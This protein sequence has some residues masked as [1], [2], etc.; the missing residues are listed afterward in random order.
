MRRITS[1]I[2]FSAVRTGTVGKTK[3]WSK[4][5]QVHRYHPPSSSRRDVMVVSADRIITTLTHRRVPFAALCRSVMVSGNFHSAFFR[6]SRRRQRKT[7]VRLFPPLPFCSTAYVPTAAPAERDRGRKD[8]T[9]TGG[10]RRSPRGGWKDNITMY[11]ARSSL[12][13]GPLSPP[14]R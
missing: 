1:A 11:D 8:V 6:V 13:S 14:H 3:S 5:R 2:T 10:R 4:T 12:R 7:T 9:A